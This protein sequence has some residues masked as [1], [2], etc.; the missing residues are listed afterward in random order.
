MKIVRAVVS[1]E[2]SNNSDK[3]V[4]ALVSDENSNGSDKWWKY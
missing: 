4:I 3:I 1:V 2:N